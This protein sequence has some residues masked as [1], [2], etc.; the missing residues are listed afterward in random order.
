M[1]E[2]NGKLKISPGNSSGNLLGVF[3]RLLPMGRKGATFGL[4]YPKLLVSMRIRHYK[5]MFVEPPIYRR[6]VAL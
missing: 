1:G 2:G 3:Y 5:E 6:Y 4:K